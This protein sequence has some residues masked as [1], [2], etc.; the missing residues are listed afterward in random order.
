M[1]T[2]QV[3]FPSKGPI[4]LDQPDSLDT[5]F[6]ASFSSRILFHHPSRDPLVRREPIPS[7]VFEGSK[8][9]WNYSSFEPLRGGVPFDSGASFAE[10]EVDEFGELVL[11]TVL[12]GDDGPL[13]GKDGSSE[14]SVEDEGFFEGS[15]HFDC[16]P[17]LVCAI[18]LQVYQR[19]G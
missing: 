19:R 2:S 3:P 18:L 11:P 7:S 6:A 1:D 9:P 14:S 16:D 10:F 12:W 13:L 17:H 8:D 4:L 15:P 5:P